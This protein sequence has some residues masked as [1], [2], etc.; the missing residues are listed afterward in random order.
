MGPG[1]KASDTQ[2]LGSEAQTLYY[3][4]KHI[5]NSEKLQ[6][7]Q[8]VQ[9][10]WT[11]KIL[12]QPSLKIFSNALLK[13]LTHLN[14]CNS[15]RKSIITSHLLSRNLCARRRNQYPKFQYTRMTQE[16]WSTIYFKFYYEIIL[17]DYETNPILHAIARLLSLSL[18]ARL[19]DIYFIIAYT[20]KEG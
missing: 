1:D 10:I 12:R 14:L 8:K 2:H 16:T 7:L 5:E 13:R 18:S 4:L 6:K 17:L 11:K 19:V 3:W 20:F 15:Q 9:K